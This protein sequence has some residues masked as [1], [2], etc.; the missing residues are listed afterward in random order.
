MAE[1]LLD[2]AF[3]QGRSGERSS[4]APVQADVE[5]GALARMIEERQHAAAM[6]CT[7]VS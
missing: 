4:L 1:Q 7:V 2:G 3:R 6:R 5:L